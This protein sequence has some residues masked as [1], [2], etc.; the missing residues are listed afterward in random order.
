MK[1]IFKMIF[2]P[3]GKNMIPKE[4]SSL[5]YLLLHGGIEVVEI[6]YRPGESLYSFTPKM[7]D[8]MPAIYEEHVRDVNSQILVLW[9]KDFLEINMM[10]DDPLISISA[11]ALDLKEVLTLSQE[12]QWHLKEIK[13][14]LK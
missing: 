6:N 14:L 9:E 2:N 7:K 4:Q 5:D 13:R 1:K 11:K 12:E 10:E 3:E 8:L